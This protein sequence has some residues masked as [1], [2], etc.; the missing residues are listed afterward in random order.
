[1]AIFAT[2]ALSERAQ[3]PVTTLTNI[4]IAKFAIWM[5]MCDFLMVKNGTVFKKKLAPTQQYNSACL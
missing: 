2:H 1:M 3:I 4:I 5:P